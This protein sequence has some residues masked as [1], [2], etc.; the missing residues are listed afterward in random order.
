MGANGGVDEILSH[1]WLSQ[2]DAKA[3]LAK[4]VEPPMK[5]NLS[6]DPLDV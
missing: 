6:T 2:L 3:I 4:E 1:P 5:P